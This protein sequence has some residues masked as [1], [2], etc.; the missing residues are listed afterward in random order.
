MLIF[1][2]THRLDSDIVWPYGTF[3]DKE[4]NQIVAPRI[5]AKWRKVDEKF[6]DKKLL[7]IAQSKTENLL[8]IVSHCGAVSN[9]DTLINKLM[10]F[11]K[12]DIYGKCGKFR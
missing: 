10:S 11:I 7:Q 2:V 4:T 8:G 12:F 9:R 1:S 6:H 5:H 3:T